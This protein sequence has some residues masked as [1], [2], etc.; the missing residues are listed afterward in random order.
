MVIRE[1]GARKLFK[2][3]PTTIMDI[4]YEQTV[5]CLLPKPQTLP[6]PL[7]PFNVGVIMAAITS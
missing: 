3:S 7:P 2:F 5:Y 1:D 4:I 6:P